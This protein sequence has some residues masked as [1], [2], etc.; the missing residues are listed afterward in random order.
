MKAHGISVRTLRRLPF[1]LN[2]LVS[3]DRGEDKYI[4]AAAIA[5]VLKLNEVQVRK[6]LSAACKTPGVPKKGF[7]ISDLIS[8]LKECLG[9][10]NAHDAI[11]VGAG[12]LGRALL[13][14][15]G[16]ERYG[17]NIISAFDLYEDKLDGKDIYKIEKLSDIIKEQNVKIAIITV[18]ESYAQSVC[19]TLTA[20]GILAIW[21][22]APVHLNVP[23]GVLVQNENMAAS[24]A[25]LSNHLKEQMMEVTQ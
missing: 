23:S 5:S 7:L 8:G 13:G 6:D 18:P 3:V 24:L 15:K 14:Y 17:L 10:N 22:F 1:Y 16:F 21:N 2:Y 9:H 20:N 12:N 4:S 25:M 11:L 19:D